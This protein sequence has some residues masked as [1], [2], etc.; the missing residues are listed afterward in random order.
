MGNNHR[1]IKGGGHVLPENSD[2][3]KRVRDGK[4]E[5]DR[6]RGKIEKK[7]GGS[8]KML[9]EISGTNK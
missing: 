1:R 8:F 7:N 9:P 5:I 3:E 2:R 4:R 6:E